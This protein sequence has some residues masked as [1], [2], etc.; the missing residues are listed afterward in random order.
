MDAAKTETE[1]TLLSY[2]IFSNPD[3]LCPSTKALLRLVVSN[4]LGDSVTCRRI[5]LTLPV[6]P[7]ATDLIESG[8]PMNVPG[9]AAP[10]HSPADRSSNQ[11]PSGAASAAIDG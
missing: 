10:S 7:N 6:G 2:S 3:P 11:G 5:V 8:T 1:T 9:A 4:P